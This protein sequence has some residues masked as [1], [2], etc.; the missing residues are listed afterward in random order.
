MTTLEAAMLAKNFAK[1]MGYEGLSNS[2]LIQH[3]QL[4]PIH[5]IMEV[6]GLPHVSRW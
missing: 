3:L 5:S 6:Q 1:V 4:E 2:I